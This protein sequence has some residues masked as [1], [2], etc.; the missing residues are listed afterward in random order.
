MANF[1]PRRLRWLPVS[2]SS[3]R[4]MS[5]VASEAKLQG[6]WMPFT[7]NRNFKSVEKPKMFHRAEG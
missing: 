7:H 5:T 2:T 3:Y 4:S 1:V 6:Y